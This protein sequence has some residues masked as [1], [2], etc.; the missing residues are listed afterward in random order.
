MPFYEISGIKALLIIQSDQSWIRGDVVFT[1]AH[2][3][4]PTFKSWLDCIMA[5][6]PDKFSAL[7]ED[8]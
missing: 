7:I 6:L 4:S 3:Y 5:P 2:C 1:E 8:L